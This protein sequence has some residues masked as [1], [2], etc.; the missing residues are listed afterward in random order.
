MD[1]LHA[2]QQRLTAHTTMMC[3]QSRTLIVQTRE[4]I[5]QSRTIIDRPALMRMPF[6]ILTDP[7]VDGLRRSDLRFEP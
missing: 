6:L 3:S 7:V 2:T 5:A 4:A 1:S